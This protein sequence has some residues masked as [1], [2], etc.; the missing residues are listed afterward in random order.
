MATSTEMCLNSACRKNEPVIRF[1]FRVKDRQPESCGYPGFNLSC[2]SGRDETI[3]ELPSSGEFSVRGIDYASQEIW[4]NDPSNCL[5]R[6]LL[7]FSLSGSP[8]S[9]VHYQNFTFLN[10]S[11]EF[12]RSRFKRITCLSGSSYTV[13]A[14]SSMTLARIVSSSCGI[15]STVSVP[16]QWPVYEPGLSSDLSEDLY[17]TWGAPSCGNCEARGG[18]CGFK[19]NTSRAIVCSDIPRHGLP[20]SGRYAITIGV[21]VP[22]LMCVIGLAC[23]LCGRVKT[24]GRRHRPVAE[25][26]SAT[27][28]PHI[29]TVVGLD[30]PTIESYPKLVLGESLR[31]PKPNDSTC[32]ICLSEYKPKDTLRSIPECKHCFHV[33]CI[34]AWLPMNATCPVCRNSPHQLPPASAT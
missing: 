17:L 11:S 6:R 34:D 27:V 5:P 4:I 9:G 7:D 10:C 20:R 15:I 1:P 24:Y 32:A 21:G 30:G 12:E 31:V 23:Y 14:T 29:I 25:S 3:L 19:S 28:S 8:F 33:D 26:S 2:D 16:I 13:W 18:R 22:A